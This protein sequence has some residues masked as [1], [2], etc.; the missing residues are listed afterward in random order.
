LSQQLDYWKRQLDG[1]EALQLPTDRPRSLMQT[2]RGG[3]HNFTLSAELTSAIQ[4]LSRRAGVTLYMS[5]LAA[6]Q[7]LLARYSNQND[8]SIGTPIAGRSRAEIEPLIGFFVNTLVM[9][10]DLSGNP[11][12]LELLARV[13]EVCLAAYAHQD[14]PFEKLVEE[15]QPERNLSRTPLFQVMIVLQNIPISDFHLSDLTISPVVMENSSAKFDLMLLLAESKQGVSGT[16]EYN[17][18]LFDETTITRLADH[19][20]NLLAGIINHPQHNIMVLPL[21]SKAEGHRL[22]VEWNNTTNIEYRNQSMHQRFQDQVECT[23]AATA[24]VFE[25]ERLSY[26][27]LN[28]RAN[29]LAHYLRT[30]GVREEVLVGICMQRCSKMIV[31]MLAVLKAGGAYL[32]LDPAYPQERIEFMLAD[33]QAPIVLT[34]TS[35]LE[36]LGSQPA[37]LVC[38]DRD[39]QMIA[40]QPDDN[41]AVYVQAENSAYVIYTSG[42]T[43]RPKG[44][45]I[46]HRS[47]HTFIKW[48]Q[49]IYTS[50]QLDGVL[51]STSIC[52]DLSIYE[53]FV[54]LSCGG[55]VILAENALSLPQVQAANE[56]TLIN[57]VPSAMAELVRSRSIPLSVNTVNLA[58]E[59][60]Q[61]ALVQQIYELE[62]V[63]A[64]YNLYGPS[65]D[66]TYSTYAMIKRGTETAPTIG[67]PIANTQIYILDRLMQ[68]V[69]IGVVAELCIAGDGLSRGYLNRPDV[70][71]EKFVPHPYSSQ[72]GARLYRTGDLARYLDDG[73]IEFLGRLDHQVKLRGYRIE[74]AEIESVLRQHSSVQ[75]C[76]VIA[77]EDSIGDKRLVAYIV[78][79][80][81]EEFTL[82]EMR[83]YLKPRLPEYMIP[84]ATVIMERL[85][86]T[87]NGKLD[88]KALPA[89][90]QQHGHVFIAPRDEYELKLARLWQEI[91]RV[92]LVGVQDSFFELGGHSL[93]AVRMMAQVQELFDQHLPLS[94]LFQNSTVEQLAAILRKLTNNLTTSVLVAIQPQGNKQPFFCIHPI[95]GNIF[96]YV[97]LAR[98]L[99]SDQPFYGIQSIGLD[100]ISM[101]L[102]SIEEMA[103]LYITEMRTVQPIG[104]YCLGGWSMGGVVAFEMAQQLIRNGEQVKLLALLDST[105]PT[106]DQE[107][108]HWQDREILTRFVVN[109]IPEI[110]GQSSQLYQELENLSF[111]EQLNLILTKAKSTHILPVDTGF[112]QF[113]QLY[114]VYKTNTLAYQRY[115]PQLYPQQLTLFNA[116]ERYFEAQADRRKVW[117]ELAVAVAEFQ[118]PGDHYNILTR[119]N[120]EILAKAL[121]HCLDAVYRTEKSHAPATL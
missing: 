106:A 71:A 7:V 41:P 95:G 112:L 80:N 21:L 20:E 34:Q 45:V 58:G 46:E 56:V 14:L 78:V 16:F 96:C 76:V 101:P 69:P 25:Q 36:T 13:R 5:L 91:L 102:T 11:S 24:L 74:L 85:P 100:G 88:R 120:V 51:A 35:W 115:L 32:P 33:T 94:I 28:Q 73:N 12:F 84:A 57:T 83:Q 104:P 2:H 98:C 105:P 10:T 108:D 79:V 15:L 26:R 54:P 87:P 42:S 29:Q 111:A 43:G 48:S 72:A 55:K 99:G 114:Q 47:A 103:A 60:L 49:Q 89:P 68:A 67:R 1:A 22:L 37:Q 9:R 18:G 23:P 119:P 86:L 30:I 62:S 63:E 8:I 65:E 17:T 50:K 44:V 93:L 61:N 59:P 38:L 109:L 81:A 117:K 52:F 6:L 116:N 110:A 113:N 53:I 39:W 70:T 92:E 82:T 118:I 19:Y 77:R 40:E 3:R 121:K 27:E 64:V 97:E 90:E 66:T 75:E 31:A 4:E 107:A